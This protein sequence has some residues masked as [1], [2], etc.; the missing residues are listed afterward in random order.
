MF[1][2]IK[3]GK[4]SHGLTLLLTLIVIPNQAAKMQRF[5][6]LSTLQTL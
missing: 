3:Y 5:H 6:A 1:D 4:P 2:S